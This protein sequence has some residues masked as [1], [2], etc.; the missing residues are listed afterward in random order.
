LRFRFIPQ[1]SVQSLIY[2]VEGVLYIVGKEGIV[3]GSCV[4]TGAGTNGLTC[5]STGTFVEGVVVGMV[6]VGGTVLTG[7]VDGTVV[8]LDGV[9]LVVV[10]EGLEIVVYL[11]YLGVYPEEC[12]EW[13][14]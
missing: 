11:L 9:I 5:W 3:A 8:G 12:D 2:G 7:F 13:D 14:A 1:K 10:P 6:W 4:S